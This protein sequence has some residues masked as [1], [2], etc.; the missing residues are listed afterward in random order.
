MCVHYWEVSSIHHVRYSEVSLYNKSYRNIN[1]YNI[2]M[3]KI[4]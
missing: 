1:R 2:K 3:I 4:A